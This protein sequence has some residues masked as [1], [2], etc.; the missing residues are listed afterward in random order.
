MYISE[1][2]VHVYN[3]LATCL[4]QRCHGDGDDPGKPW[5]VVMAETCTD[6]HI[7]KREQMDIGRIGLIVYSLK[8]LYMK[9]MFVKISTKNI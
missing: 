8:A 7:T 5:W 1:L 2:R 6:L 3:Q 4:Q 9:D